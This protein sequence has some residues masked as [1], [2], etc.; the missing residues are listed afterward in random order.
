MGSFKGSR[1]GAGAVRVGKGAGPAPG[2]GAGPARTSR[3]RINPAAGCPLLVLLL[4]LGR[5]A[6]ADFRHLA[7]GVGHDRHLGALLEGV[8]L[9]AVLRGQ[10]LLLVAG[11]DDHLGRVAD[12]E[13]LVHRFLLLLDRHGQGT[14]RGIDLLDGAADRLALLLFLLACQ[15]QARAK[16]QRDRRTNERT[17]HGKAPCPPYGPAAAGPGDAAGTPPASAGP[18]CEQMNPGANSPHAS[19]REPQPGRSVRPEG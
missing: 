5:V 3:R 17:Q 7:V 16:G 12:L 19:P 13:L 14:G 9:E 15:R 18:S 2:T 10:F 8:A 6:D 11:E 1:G 4:L